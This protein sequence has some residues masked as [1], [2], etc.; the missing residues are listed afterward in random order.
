MANR[1]KL[2]DYERF[3]AKTV[4]ADN[5]CLLWTA[6]KNDFGHGRF[7]LRGKTILAHRAAW[8]IEY[9]EILLT[10]Q[11]LLH[12][13]D[14]PACVEVAH[15]RV[16]THA[17]NM[18]DRAARGRYGNTA[19]PSRFTEADFE[20]MREM[21]AAGVLQR[22]IAQFFGCT[23]SY[24]SNVKRGK[25]GVSGPRPEPSQGLMAKRAA[26]ARAR[27]NRLRI[28]EIASVVHPDDEIDGE[29]W[30]ET[31]FEGYWVSSLGRVRGRTMRILKQFI[32]PSGYA[33]VH[34]GSRNPRRVHMLV[35]EA[36][37]GPCP[38]PGMHA[39][40]GNGDPVDNRPENLRWATPLEN[41]QDRIRLGTVA[42]GERVGGSKLT[43][44]DVRTIRA[45]LTGTQGEVSRLAREYG[46]E[47][48]TIRCIRDNVT[49]RHVA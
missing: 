35:C 34:F 44:N 31:R 47:R 40:H 17:E 29:V 42:R 38:A 30:R 24:I 1:S 10:E 43:E 3:Y 9:G 12:A 16:G 36:W 15:L 13:C 27:A 21:L 32:N 11:F 8:L 28:A 5:G 23:Q 25:A 22:T 49:W 14:T 6:G 33:V 39:A 7:V 46:V 19:P 2:T 41:A 20:R 26:D 48:Y 4:R 18:A 45:K 37:H